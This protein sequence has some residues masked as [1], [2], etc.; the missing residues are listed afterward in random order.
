MLSEYLPSPIEMIRQKN[1][2]QKELKEAN[3]QIMNCKLQL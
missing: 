2:H 3:N 1:N